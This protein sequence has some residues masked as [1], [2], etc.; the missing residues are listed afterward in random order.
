MAFALRK[1]YRWQ[2]SFTR[3]VDGPRSEA[4]DLNKIVCNFN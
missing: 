4:P 2:E 1:A 3:K